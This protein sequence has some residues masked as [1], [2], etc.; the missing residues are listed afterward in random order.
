M[1]TEHK[2]NESGSTLIVALLMLVVLALLAANT[3]RMAVPRF[4]VSYQT[5]AWQE[6]RLA[7]EAGV[8]M[9]IQRLNQNAP[10]PWDED[11]ADWTG[12]KYEDGSDVN[13]ADI[14]L[15]NSG[16]VSGIV[17][18]GAVGLVASPTIYLDNVPV[19]GTD[20]IVDV[21]LSAL[22]PNKNDLSSTGEPNSVWFRIRAMG[23]SK[24]P[25][26]KR[27]AADRM[28][29]VLRRLNFFGP[30]RPQLAVNDVGSPNTIG[31]PNAARVVE[32]LV[33][34]VFVFSKAIITDER[35]ELPNSNGWE[36][37]SY[38]ST[39]P[40]KSGP[41]GIYPGEGDAKIQS[42]GDIAS[43]LPK[44]Y[45]HGAGVYGDVSTAGGDIAST[46]TWENVD[47]GD[48][49]NNTADGSVNNIL[50]KVDD[51]FDEV[52][53]P[54]ARPIPSGI[55]YPDPGD[56]NGERLFTAA[57][58][59]TKYYH[60]TSGDSDLGSFTVTGTGNVV[61]LLD[62][63]WSL[64]S[65]NGAYVNIPPSATVTVY[66]AENISFGNGNVNITASSNGTMVAYGTGSQGNGSNIPANLTIIGEPRGNG[67]TTPQWLQADGNANI[68]AVFYGPSYN[69]EAKGTDTWYGS[70]VSKSWTPNGGGNAG[71]H[72]D[73][74]LG[75]KGYISR[76]EISSYVEDNRQ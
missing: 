26:P 6:A 69:I 41:G 1:K 10:K 15:T 62:R 9:A 73:E 43:K 75:R 29:S 51:D 31:F 36:V 45:L 76:F 22:Y 14:S 35:L 63:T 47:G 64:G 8:D 57:P 13:A 72:Y 52:I 7:A 65:G 59:T 70:V 12:W 44:V 18:T 17:A 55:V 33:R 38:D 50:G 5:A 11:V 3:L 4:H 27:S 20:N 53:E 39:D 25:G 30:L 21:Q 68:A 42:N 54:I 56:I 49:A 74:S 19:T 2:H 48:E 37:D 67:D 28:D 46:P 58:G 24:V 23:M 60:I 16:T 34:P 71:F 61:I 66:T 32:V 40:N